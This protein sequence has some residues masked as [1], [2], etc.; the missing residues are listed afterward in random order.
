MTSLLALLREH[1]CFSALPSSSRILLETPRK[2]EGISEMCGGKYCHFGLKG[3]LERYLHCS[4][5]L[6]DSVL[7]SFNI[8]GL[9]LSK[10]SKDQFWPIMAQAK[11]RGN[12]VPSLVGV[13]YGKCKPL[14]ANGFLKAFVDKLQELLQQSVPVRDKMVTVRLGAIVC[15]APAKA[16]I[17]SIKGHS[18]YY[19]CSKCTTKGSYVNGKVCFPNLN[20]DL[21]T[22]L[23]FRNQLQ[24]NHHLGETIL[25]QL[26]ID[27]VKQVPLDYMHLICLGVMHKLLAL[28]FKTPWKTHA[29]FRLSSCV[30]M[31]FQQDTWS[32]HLL[33]RVISTV[34]HEA[35]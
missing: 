12:N 3:G 27:I 23:S 35:C 6:P 25:T 31:V 21:R 33:F 17:L 22:N 20:A 1:A 8:D 10:S 26:P 14:E 18:G 5:E 4:V 15:D 24:E 32:F 2:A 16:F 13:F 19:S 9:L 28:W 30:R 11:D 34:S 29:S 7:L